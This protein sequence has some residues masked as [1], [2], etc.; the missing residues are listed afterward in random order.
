GPLVLTE[1][2]RRLR[3]A[4]HRFIYAV[5]IDLS[6]CQREAGLGPVEVIQRLQAVGALL[7][8]RLEVPEFDLDT[9]LPAA[10]VCYQALV[11][12]PEPPDALARLLDLPGVHLVLLEPSL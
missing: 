3:P 6:R 8:A 4:G 5:Q 1:D 10:G 2:T 9:T 12:S 11:S 7:D